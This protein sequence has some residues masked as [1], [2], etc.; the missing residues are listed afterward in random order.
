M[1]KG[2]SL[3]TGLLILFAFSASAILLL[4]DVLPHGLSFLAHAP[5]SAAPLLFI[6]GASLTFLLVTRPKPLDLLKALLVSL[7]FILWGIDQ[8]LPVGWLA[9]TVGDVVITLYVI[10]LGWMMAAILRSR[11]LSQ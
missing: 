3:F 10:D 4:R 6:G 9:T 5:V 2:L 7:A 8:L 11:L 1:R